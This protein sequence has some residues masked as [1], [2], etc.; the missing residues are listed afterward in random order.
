MSAAKPASFH[1]QSQTL[2]STG[3]IEADAAQA[4]AAEAFAALDAQLAHYRP[5][6]R[7]AGL[8]GRLF[9]NGNVVSRNNVYG[10][11]LAG[12]GLAEVGI[13]VDDTVFGNVIDDNQVRWFTTGLQISDRIDFPSYFRENLLTGNTTPAVGGVDIG[14]NI[15]GNPPLMPPP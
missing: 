9:G 2:V 4:H 1:S 5:A 13:L 8:L 12:G 7:K 3:E 11:W 6:A 15:M 10:K 14:G